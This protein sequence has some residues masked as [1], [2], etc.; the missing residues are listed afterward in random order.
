[1][2]ILK[3][4]TRYALTP[5]LMVCSTFVLFAQTSATREYQIKAAFLFNFTQ[6]VEW[7]S[8]A[9]SSPNAPLVIGV[10]GKDPFAGYIEETVSGE[11]VNGHPLIVQHYSSTEDIKTCH[12]LFINQA[13]NKQAQY[14]ADLKGRS[15]LT[16]SDT[17]DFLKQNGMI[18]FYTK[19][20]K[21]QLQINLDATK[22]SKLTISS[23]LLRLAEIFVP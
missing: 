23:K 20:N 8:S 16:V 13:E 5:I 3:T 18:R 17:P 21:I 4:I 1:M 22:T 10:L 19:N 11:N 14:I 2:L 9:F 15:I 7:P 12:V 6:F